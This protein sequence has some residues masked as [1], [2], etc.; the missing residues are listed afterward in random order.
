[1]LFSTHNHIRMNNEPDLR[2]YFAL[3]FF[4]S[5]HILVLSLLNRFCIDSNGPQMLNHTDFHVCH[6][7]FNYQQEVSSVGFK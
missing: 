6:I 3:A 7:L 2:G 5:G 4:F 1:M